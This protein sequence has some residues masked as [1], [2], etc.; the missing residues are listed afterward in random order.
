MQCYERQSRHISYSLSLDN[1]FSPACGALQLSWPQRSLL[2]LDDVTFRWNREV[3]ALGLQGF[4][5]ARRRVADDS[6]QEA[7]AEALLRRCESSIECRDFS[8]S[9]GIYRDL[10][11]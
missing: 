4:R 10:F 6:H 3:S 8:L 1:S 9:E 11:E 2:A 5:D 7:Q